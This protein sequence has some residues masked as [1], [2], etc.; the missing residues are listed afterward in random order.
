LL[1]IWIAPPLRSTA[2][3]LHRFDGTGC[4]RLRTKAILQFRDNPLTG[5]MT[6]LRR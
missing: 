1:T 5:K 3:G 6:L 2:F 4:L